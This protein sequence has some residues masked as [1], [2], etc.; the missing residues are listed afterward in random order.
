MF[1]GTLPLLLLLLLWPV[2]PV[3][4]CLRCSPIFETVQTQLKVPIQGL[5]AEQKQQ[6]YNVIMEIG[7]KEAPFLFDFDDVAP[8][9][10]KKIVD[11][12]DSMKP[13]GL[14]DSLKSMKIPGMLGGKND[15][16]VPDVLRKLIALSREY[17]EVIQQL[18]EAPCENCGRKSV[19]AVKCG[20][21]ERV[22]IKCSACSFLNRILGNPDLLRLLGCSMLVVIL[23]F[24]VTILATSFKKEEDPQ[25]VMLREVLSQKEFKPALQTHSKKKKKKSSGHK[26]P[27]S[28]HHSQ[29]KSPKAGKTKQTPAHPTTP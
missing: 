12:I 29:N 21:C 22:V 18:A 25:S 14:F 7:S 11:I 23:I 28:K 26:E 5:S 6:V 19:P 13:K 1:P 15:V 2:S 17:D 4:C 10:M 3:L 27:S 20:T 24:I 9:Y 8:I 16:D